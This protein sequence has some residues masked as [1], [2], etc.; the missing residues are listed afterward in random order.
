[1]DLNL[2]TFDNKV[3]A[4]SFNQELKELDDYNLVALAQDTQ[5]PLRERNAAAEVLVIRHLPLIKQQARKTFGGVLNEDCVVACAQGLLKSIQKFDLNNPKQV[6]FTTYAFWDIRKSGQVWSKKEWGKPYTY[7]SPIDKTI[8][9]V[10]P[11]KEKDVYKYI[12][13]QSAL[14]SLE[15]LEQQVVEYR[16]WKGESYGNIADRLKISK[17]EV[18]RAMSGAKKKLKKELASYAP[19]SCV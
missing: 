3:L 18:S 16:F 11:A 9:D 15:P 7:E 1:M 19:A 6:K 8:Q 13:I 14:G 2:V 10:V 17:K 4:K 12:D 5:L